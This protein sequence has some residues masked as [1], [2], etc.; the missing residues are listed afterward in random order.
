VFALITTFLMAGHR[1]VPGGLGTMLES[2][3]PWLGLAVPVLLLAALLCRSW[4]ACVVVLVPAL[5]WGVMF[6]MSFVDRPGDG[7]HDLRVATQNLYARNSEPGV[8]AAR[9]IGTGAD[10]VAV[11]ELAYGHDTAALSSLSRAYPDHIVLGTVGLWSRWPLS[12]TQPVDL[13]LGWTRALRTLVKSPYGDITVYVAH[14]GSARPGWTTSRDE[15]L[16]RLSA[17]VRSDASAHLLLLGD[18]NT[19]TTDRAISRLIPPLKEAQQTAGRGFGFTWPSSFPIT[20]PDHILYR[21]IHAV[22]ASVLNTPGSD[23]RAALADFR[24]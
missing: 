5:T 4:S 6:G 18:L 7:P 14:L 16:Q 15:T 23:H 9:L 11:E 3:L 2:V 8:T 24:V 20:R 21:G 10:L 1:S 12:A 22:H 19:A 13:G 17:A